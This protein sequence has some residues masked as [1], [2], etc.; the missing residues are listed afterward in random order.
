MWLVKSEYL[1]NENVV[2][3]VRIIGIVGL[4][5]EIPLSIFLLVSKFIDSFLSGI[6]DSKAVAVF[7]KRSV[8]NL[9][10]HL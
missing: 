6:L 4:I 1:F 9:S 10:Y 8:G 2:S 7:M 3:C 5:R